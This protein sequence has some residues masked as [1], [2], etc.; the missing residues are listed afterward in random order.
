MHIKLLKSRNSK[1]IAEYSGRK[2]R[3]NVAEIIHQ[4]DKDALRK[5]RRYE[6]SPKQDVRAKN[7]GLHFEISPADNEQGNESRIIDLASEFLKGMN[8]QEQPWLLVRHSDIKRVHYHLVTTRAT[9]SAQTISN[10]WIRK[11]T[12]DAAEKSIKV[13]G[14]SFREKMV[15][16]KSKNADFRKERG[17][18]ISQI[19]SVFNHVME[20][21][22]KSREDFF[23]EMRTR[24]VDAWI[25]T[26]C[27]TPKL[28]FAGLSDN[29][30]RSIAPI[31]RIDSGGCMLAM[32][33][34]VIEN[35]L[36]ASNTVLT[37]SSTFDQEQNETTTNY[38]ELFENELFL[39]SCF[40]IKD[41][42]TIS[43]MVKELL[44][45]SVSHGD[46]ENKCDAVGIIICVQ[47]DLVNGLQI[48]FSGY[49]GRKLND[50]GDIQACF[51][52][53]ELDLIAH[54]NAWG[55]KQSLL[56]NSDHKYGVRKRKAR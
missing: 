50:F 11:R 3:A 23:S 27:K 44:R 55:R 4:S 56:E 9:K 7:L 20:L 40:K 32:V 41:S 5:I 48:E 54:E 49:D 36:R 8:L 53:G 10:A 35:S 43:K 21:P 6:D 28:I 47:E 34:R 16:Q 24:N 38:D 25:S 51:T 46:F 30:K 33:D 15:P 26:R 12:Y 1:S 14:F 29:G 52:R 19:E 42:R 18:V 2:I 13:M 45:E 39:D 22:L 37:Q 31:Y 17:N